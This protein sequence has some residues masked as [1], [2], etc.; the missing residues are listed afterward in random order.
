MSVREKLS[1]KFWIGHTSV[2]LGKSGYS[3]ERV[4]VRFG[5][6]KRGFHEGCFCLRADREVAGCGLFRLGIAFG[7]PCGFNV[8]LIVGV[9]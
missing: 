8:I 5:Q 9:T 1:G 2:I 6:M 3:V 7:F 4:C